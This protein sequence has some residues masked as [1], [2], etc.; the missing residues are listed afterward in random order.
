M[1][2]DSF[3]QM[4]PLVR[5]DSRPA[6]RLETGGEWALRF[7]GSSHVRFGACVAGTIWLEAAGCAPLALSP[8]DGYLLTQGQRYQLGSRP[9]IAAT[10]GMPLYR[11]ARDGRV[12]HGEA[13]GTVF[14]SGRFTFDELRSK[15]LLEVLPPVIH[16]PADCAVAP[17]LA[18][19]V[20]MLDFETS[21]PLFGA[22]LVCHHVAQVMLVQALRV[23]KASPGPEPVGWLAALADPRIGLALQAIH[24]KPGQDWSVAELANIAGMSRSLFAS[25][26]HTLAGAAPRDYLLKLRLKLAAQ[27]LRGSKRSISSIGYEVGYRSESAFSNAFKREAGCSPSE[28]RERET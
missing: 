24:G 17:A 11:A 20:R 9:G 5:V 10:D 28:F 12:F 23:I 18:A 8:G 13:R 22:G 6:A 25:R 3:S 15:Q 4:F 7:T 1:V 19:A 26:F 21:E 2:T 16:I 27:M 14:V